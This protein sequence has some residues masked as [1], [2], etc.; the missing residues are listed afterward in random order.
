MTIIETCNFLSFRTHPLSDLYLRSPS[1]PKRRGFLFMLQLGVE[2]LLFIFFIRYIFSICHVERSGS[3]LVG[4]NEVETCFWTTPFCGYQSPNEV[5]TER[6]AIIS[7]ESGGTRRS[8][9][10]ASAIGTVTTSR[11]CKL[12]ITSNSPCEA[13]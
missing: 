8:F 6:A 2:F 12:T 4:R 1:L 13:D 7:C 5:P 3:R 9:P 10:I 11:R